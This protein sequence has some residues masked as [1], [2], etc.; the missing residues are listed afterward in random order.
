MAAEQDFSVQVPKNKPTT[1]NLDLAEL[2]DTK[3]A[4][5]YVLVVGSE[6]IELRYWQDRPT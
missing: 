2:V 1:F 6:D 4:G 3:K 5:I